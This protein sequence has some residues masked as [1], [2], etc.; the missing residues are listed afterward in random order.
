MVGVFFVHIFDAEVVN[1]KGEQDRAQFVGP[2]SRGVNTFRVSE[3]GKFAT[4]VFIC[5]DPCLC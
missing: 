4:E 5:E 2:Q 3:Q 1:N